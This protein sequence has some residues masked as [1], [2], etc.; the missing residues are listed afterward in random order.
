MIW[1]YVKQPSYNRQ[2][3]YIY[4]LRHPELRG[5]A[6]LAEHC[7]RVSEAFGYSHKPVSAQE[8]RAIIQRSEELRDRCLSPTTLG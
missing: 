8:A 2:F 3:V 1:L 5:G 6:E 4:Q 7:Q